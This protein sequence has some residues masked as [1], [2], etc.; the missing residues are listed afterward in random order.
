MRKYAVLALCG[1]GLGLAVFGVIRSLPA[2]SRPTPIYHSSPLK[3]VAS[4]T[5]D[6]GNSRVNAIV[7]A[8]REAGSAVV[9]ITVTQTRTV[10]NPFFSPF[11][12]DPF[13]WFF[14]DFG[15]PREYQQQVKAMGSGLIISADGYVV[16]NAHVAEDATQITV[17]LSDG[18]QLEAEL[19]DVSSSQDLAL[20]KMN[21]KDLP[22][23][24]L[25]DSDE[26]MI[27]EWAI[28][29]GNP[30]GYLLEDTRP[31]VTVGVISATN[32]TLR[33]G[34]SEGREYKGMIQTDAAINPGN[35]GGPLVNSLGEVIGINTFI[36]TKSGGSEGIGFA[37]PINDVKKFV[38]EARTEAKAA[39]SETP[40]EKVATKI[41]ATVSDI[42]RTL[43]KKYRLTV[44]AGVIVLEIASGSIA[45]SASLEPG[46][47]ITAVAGQKVKN[48]ADF[49]A[50]AEKLGRSLDLT[51]NRQGSQIRMM[52]RF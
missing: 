4:T 15:P 35:S 16:T 19:V 21:A 41:G 14:R 49:K 9:S 28:A 39:A 30:F 32:R 52:S 37:I 24:K 45:E 13:N 22:F 44:D 50:K 10:T 3:T 38:D 51:I 8:A 2:K 34:Q 12:D 36:F 27:G 42:N 17:T 40:T 31:T 48:A 23:G 26:A 5:D 25:G 18:K 20:V 46:D 33:A 1:V 29:L 47:V 7:L 43:K 6:I 11:G